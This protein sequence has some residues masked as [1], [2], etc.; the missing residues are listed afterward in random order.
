MGGE[1]LAAFWLQSSAPGCQMRRLCSLSG[2]HPA[3][4]KQFA[5]H[6]HPLPVTY[7]CQLALQVRHVSDTVRMYHLHGVAHRRCSVASVATLSPFDTCHRI[8]IHHCLYTNLRARTGLEIIQGSSIV[9]A[10][11]NGDLTSSYIGVLH[12]STHTLVAYHTRFSATLH[13]RGL[14]QEATVRAM[15]NFFNPVVGETPEVTESWESEPN[16]GLADRTVSVYSGTTLGGSSAV[17]GA[18]FSTPTNDVRWPLPLCSS[19]P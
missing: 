16:P 8:Q 19:V 9:D 15:H 3:V 18:Q 11:V 2:L 13:L 6:S 1:L 14:V 5:S 17:N 4:Q 10:I 12:M 7:L